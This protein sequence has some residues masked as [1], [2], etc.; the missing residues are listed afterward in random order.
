MIECTVEALRKSIHL[1]VM[2]TIRERK[3]LT[4]EFI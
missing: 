4:T 3:N 2:S 1:V